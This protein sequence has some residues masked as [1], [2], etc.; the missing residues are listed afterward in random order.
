MRYEVDTLKPF[1][2][3][4]ENFPTLL[5]AK[6]WELESWLPRFFSFLFFSVFLISLF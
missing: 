6:G 3:T 5:A 1:R 4:S 2:D